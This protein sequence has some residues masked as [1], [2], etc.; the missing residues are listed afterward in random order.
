RPEHRSCRL[1][2]KEEMQM[3]NR[4]TASDEQDKG[5]GFHRSRTLMCFISKYLSGETDTNPDSQDCPDPSHPAD[6]VSACSDTPFCLY[7]YMDVDLGGGQSTNVIVIGYFDQHSGMK[8]LRLLDTLQSNA[9]TNPNAQKGIAIGLSQEFVYQLRAFNSGFVSLC[10]LPELGTRACHTGLTASFSYVIDLVKDVL[11]HCS[12]FPPRNKRLKEKFTSAAIYN[13]SLPFSAQSILIM[14][15]MQKMCSLWN[16]LVEH[17]SS[18]GQ[19][20]NAR[21]ICAQLKDPKIRLHFLFLVQTLESLCTFQEVQQW[22]SSDVAADLQLASMLASSYTSRLLRPSTAERFLRRRDLALLHNDNELLPDSEVNVGVDA[23][24]FL[25]S[26]SELD[27]H[28]KRD[29]MSDVVA[30][31]K[32]AL[33]SMTDSIPEQLSDQ[34]LRNIATLLKP[35]GSVPVSICSS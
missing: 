9:D 5:R 32:A 16:D 24:N 7:L 10:G 33:E 23:S 2:W 34:A 28:D 1:R 31:F 35:S 20:E 19:E 12:T 21:R 25:A 27:E 30:F 4:K 11:R 8:V 15:T 3:K 22:G 17:F 6:I 29:F 13:S 18:L 26:T 14:R